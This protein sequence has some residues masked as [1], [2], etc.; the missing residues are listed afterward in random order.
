MEV[1]IGS[2]RIAQAALTK[3]TAKRADVLA[4]VQLLAAMRPLEDAAQMTVCETLVDEGLLYGYGA[5]LGCECGDWA[6]DLEGRLW[7]KKSIAFFS[8]V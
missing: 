2:Y 5:G 4:A 8:C 6:L 3:K 1:S 7:Q